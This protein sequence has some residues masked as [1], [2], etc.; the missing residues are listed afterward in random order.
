MTMNELMSMSNEELLN[1]ITSATNG[2][3][4]IKSLSAVNDAVLYRYI[5]QTEDVDAP[6][7]K[8]IIIYFA[9]EYE[10][11]MAEYDDYD[12]LVN[13]VLEAAEVAS[14]ETLEDIDC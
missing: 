1:I 10:I 4:G 3:S 12:D 6:F 2:K 8:Q 13:D 11:E 7:F 9:V 5:E 14:Y